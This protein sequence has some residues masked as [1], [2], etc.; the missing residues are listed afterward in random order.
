VSI[1]QKNEKEKSR[2]EK[3]IQ[4]FTPI[5]SRGQSFPFLHSSQNGNRLLQSWRCQ[6]LSFA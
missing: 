2:K 6:S 1:L 5:S 4:I 3:V